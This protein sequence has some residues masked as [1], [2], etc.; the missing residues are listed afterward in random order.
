M[1]E[2]TA[3][4]CHKGNIQIGYIQNIFSQGDNRIGMA[5][6][7]KVKGWLSWV[8]YYATLLALA[9]CAGSG[10]RLLKTINRID[11]RAGY[12][13]HVAGAVKG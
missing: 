6:A 2:G 1:G 11:W 7:D 5:I 8:T 9:I 3:S 4:P 12:F 13:L 10:R